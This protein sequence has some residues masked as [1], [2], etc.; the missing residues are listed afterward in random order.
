MIEAHPDG[1]V[2]G[3]PG[4]DRRPR[5]KEGQSHITRGQEDT[6]ALREARAREDVWRFGENARQ[7]LLEEAR[8]ETIFIGTPTSAQL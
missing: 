4:G 8:T 7:I 6:L 1:T 3:L 2:I 5:R